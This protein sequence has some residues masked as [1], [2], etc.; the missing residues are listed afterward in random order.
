MNELV[1]LCQTR[2]YQISKDFDNRILIENVVVNACF[3]R[4][5]VF[6]GIYFWRVEIK[7]VSLTSVL[8]YSS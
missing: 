3:D 4:G 1:R 8:K 2:S 7:S 6:S 5:T